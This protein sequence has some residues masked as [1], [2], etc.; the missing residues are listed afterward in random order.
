MQTVQDV[1]HNWANCSFN[2]SQ[3]HCRIEELILS[4]WVCAVLF[5]DLCHFCGCFYV[6]V[7]QRCFS[8]DQQEVQVDDQN[9]A[10]IGRPFSSWSKPASVSTTNQMF[11]GG[12]GSRENRT[13]RR[14][15]SAPSLLAVF[16]VNLKQ[17]DPLCAVRLC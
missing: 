14:R 11:D 13:I 3:D 8:K 2:V 12:I 16:C 1:I 4:C 6:A 17:H 7:N 5:W 10:L 9:R 15:L